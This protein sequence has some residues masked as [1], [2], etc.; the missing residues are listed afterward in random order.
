MAITLR[1]QTAEQF[2]ARLRERYRNS[3]KEEC[4]RLATWLYDSYQAGDFT[5]LQLRTAFGMN[6]TQFSAFVV[7]IQELREHWLAIQAAGGE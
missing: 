2:A 5:A 6:T 7:K 1:H 4:A 3:S